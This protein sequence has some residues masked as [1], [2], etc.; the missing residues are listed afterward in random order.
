MSGLYDVKDVDQAY[1]IARMH[2]MDIHAPEVSVL[3]DHIDD[4][5]AVYVKGA[6]R[7]TGLGGELRLF[8][9]KSVKFELQDT[10]SPSQWIFGARVPAV[11]WSL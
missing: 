6:A 3:V 11:R 7:K 5:L 9:T 1:V 8:D 4:C 2:Q 10:S